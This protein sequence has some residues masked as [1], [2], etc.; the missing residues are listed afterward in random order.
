M[1]R[2]RLIAALGVALT[3]GAGLLILQRWVAE[4]KLAAI[5]LVGAW[6][7]LVGIGALVLVR[8]RPDLR[9]PVLG[10]FAAIVLASTVVGYFT[11]F[12]DTTVNEDVVMASVRVDDRDRETA[13]AGGTETP[14]KAEREAK[15]EQEPPG[16]VELLS[17][18]VVGADGHA[19]SGD[20]AVIEAPDGTRHLTLTDFDVD[21]GAKVV[22]WLTQDETSFEDRLDLGALK[23]NV[24]DQQYELPADADL[25]K[26]DTLVI[27]CTPFTVRIAVAP[28]S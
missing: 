5:A 2:S 8:G 12:R 28:L 15:A 13:L 22:V 20:A 7:F 11:G 16:P 26:Y 9:V 17:G 21:P 4:T 1:T 6:F 27:Y 19:G 14:A 24:G 3:L 23:G 18:K 10:T 25:R